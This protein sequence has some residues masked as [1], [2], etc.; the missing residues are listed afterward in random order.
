MQPLWGKH[1][2]FSKA[3]ADPKEMRSQ[4]KRLLYT[5]LDCSAMHDNWMW[6]QSRWFLTDDSVNNI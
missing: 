2:E 5:R 4:V 1:E 6:Y 3:K